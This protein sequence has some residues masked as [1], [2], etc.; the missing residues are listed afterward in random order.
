MFAIC[1]KKIRIIILSEE[2]LTDHFKHQQP[3]NREKS[4]TAQTDS[5]FI[6]RFI[7]L[8]KNFLKDSQ[9]IQ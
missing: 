6:K 2:N 9:E 8:T 7:W 3:L 4:T 1:L 5:F